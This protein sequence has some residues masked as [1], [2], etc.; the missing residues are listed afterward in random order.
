LSVLESEGTIEA[1]D[2][3]LIISVLRAL[4]AKGVRYRI[5]GGVALNL[6]GLARATVDLDIFV[7]PDDDNIARLRAALQS[8]FADPEIDQITAEDLRGRYPAIQYVPP[9]GSFHIDILARLG[10]AFTFDQIDFEEL[11]VEG[12]VVPVATPRMLYT[13]KKDTVRL[14]DRADAD[15]LRRHYHLDED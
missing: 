13:M 7:S 11:E 4:G 15:R 6:Q 2:F 14:Q 1:M 3:D 12:V 9:S 5:V 10:E 8:V